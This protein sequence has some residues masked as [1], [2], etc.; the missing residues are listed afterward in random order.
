MKTRVIFMAL[1]AGLASASAIAAD[2]I[3]T[4][5]NLGPVRI[6]MTLAEA[7]GALQVKL[8]SVYPDSPKSCWFGNR[9][10]GIDGPVSYWIENDKV[11]AI[12][13]DDHEWPKPETSVPPVATERG[14]RMAPPRLPLRTPTSLVQS[15]RSNTAIEIPSIS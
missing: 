8:K 7:E 14:I 1:I 11:V 5:T 3:L 15:P 2:Q 10:D 6:G 9:A 12:D 13:I 4:F